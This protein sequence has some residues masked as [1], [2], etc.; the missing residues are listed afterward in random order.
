MYLPFREVLQGLVIRCGEVATFGF[1]HK[2]RF[3]SGVQQKL[4]KGS[5]ERRALRGLAAPRGREKSAG[6]PGRRARI[7]VCVVSRCI[8]FLLRFNDVHLWKDVYFSQVCF[9]KT[10]L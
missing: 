10:F 6:C 8:C 1:A 5:E 3:R 9:S 7:T 2:G 4:T